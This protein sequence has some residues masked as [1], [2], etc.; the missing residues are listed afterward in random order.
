MKNIDR[1]IEKLGYIQGLT[2]IALSY[3]DT[4]ESVIKG[5]YKVDTATELQDRRKTLEKAYE[6]AEKFL[7][8]AARENG[9]YIEIKGRPISLAYSF[10]SEIANIDEENKNFALEVIE[11]K[12]K[13]IKKR[14]IESNVKFNEIDWHEPELNDFYLSV[15]E[16]IDIT[17]GDVEY[18]IKQFKEK[19]KMESMEK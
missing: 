18:A 16:A 2:S 10:E 3:L 4:C 7:V 19:S 12:I 6:Q 11:A 15:V 5:V 13:D 1:P 8:N 14:P 17:M 9:E